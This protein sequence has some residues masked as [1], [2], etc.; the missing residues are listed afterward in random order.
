M[1]LVFQERQREVGILKALGASQGDIAKQFILESVFLTLLG[2]VGGLA[3][4]AVGLYLFSMTWTNI[5]FQ[6]VTS[7]LPFAT[8]LEMILVSVVLGTLG[9]VYPILRSW[10]LSPVETLRME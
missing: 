2:G 6:L 3:I 1:M 4:S 8:V 10:R 5:Q 7:P 9:S